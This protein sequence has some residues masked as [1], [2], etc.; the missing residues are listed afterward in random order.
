MSPKTALITGASSGIGLELSKLFAADG[1]NLILVARNTNKLEQLAAELTQAH[2]AKRGIKIVVLPKDL[3]AL[4]AP[5]EIF[6]AVQAQG[7]QVDVLVNNAGFG[8]LGAFAD[9]N[10]DEAMQMLQLNIAALTALTHLFL[11]G[12]LARKQG[13]ILNVGSTGSFG[14]APLMAVYGATKA[15]VL[16]FSEALSEELRGSNVTVT[17]LCPGVTFT[18]FQDRSGVHEIGYV[19]LGGMQ[20]DVVARIGYRMMQRGRTVVVPGVINQFLIFSLRLIP[21]S[22]ARRFSMM[23][24]QS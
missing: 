13:R 4:Q 14:P 12:M 15:Y 24:M 8:V 23:L 9:A 7:L 18:G 2:G 3:S 5:R 17:A 11:P 22:W 10:L 6:E 19:R 21:R 16:A 1:Y 20:A